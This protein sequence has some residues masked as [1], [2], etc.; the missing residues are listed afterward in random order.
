M[1]WRNMHRFVQQVI[2]WSTLLSCSLSSLA[3]AAE[4][5]ILPSIGTKAY[6]NSNLILTPFPHDATYG[7]WVSPA[8]EFAGKTERFEASGR[9]A[10]DFVSY[11]GGEETQF[12]NIFL[13]LTLR[14]RTETDVFGFTG[15]YTRDNTLMGEL[16]TTGVV[17]RFTQRDLWSANPTWTR[18]LTEKLSLRTAFQFADAAYEDGLRLGLVD[19]Q[20]LGASAGL[21]YQVDEQ[22]MVQVTGSYTNYHTTSS[23]SPFRAYFPGVTAEFT[24]SFTETLTANVYGGS[25]YVNSTTTTATDAVKNRKTIWVFGAGLTQ[26]FEHASV[27]VKASRD[28][29]PSGF[30]LLIQTDRIGVLAS[31]D[32]TETVT[33]S[34]D[35]AGYLVSGVT[36]TAS[37]G[38]FPGQ[39][40]AHAS[41]RL[42]WKFFD[43]W[44]LEASYTY[45]WRDVDTFANTATS[46]AA[47][48]TLTY[49]PPKL[50]MSN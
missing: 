16:L 6:Y 28:V 35:A 40:Y 33:A 45:G 18:M 50:A 24:H 46:N 8:A 26:K 9:V 30:G 1:P 37:G 15:G 10:A 43:W 29:V 22:N 14:Y 23:P 41:P 47:M 19:Y 42:S 3:G 11:Y 5:S 34:L 20:L 31:Y 49:F 25:R 32:L 7:Y 38:T 44:K 13:P 36:D 2:R 17:L 12:T 48:L 27:Q 21:G 39:R 4:W